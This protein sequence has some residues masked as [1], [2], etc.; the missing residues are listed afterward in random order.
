MVGMILPPV[1]VLKAGI[2]SSAKIQV[3]LL[4]T[5]QILGNGTFRNAPCVWRGLFLSVPPLLK[6][7]CTAGARCH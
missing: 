4:T 2:D 6:A 3:H 1:A 5:V 7:F